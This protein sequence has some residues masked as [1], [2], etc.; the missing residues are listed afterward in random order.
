LFTFGR[1]SG[2]RPG[3]FLERRTALGWSG[4]FADDFIFPAC[5]NRRA[6]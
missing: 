5:L 2:L 1:A 6:A 3:R 4:R